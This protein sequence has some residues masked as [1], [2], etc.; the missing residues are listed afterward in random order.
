MAFALVQLAL[1]A[2][3]V[4]NTLCAHT[5]P[6]RNASCRVLEKAG[7]VNVGT[8]VDAED[9]PVWRWERSALRND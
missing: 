4:V 5:L 1:S 7:F 2:T 6:E 3:P 9:G 8:V